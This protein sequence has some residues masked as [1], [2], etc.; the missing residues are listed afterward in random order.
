MS[1]VSEI[2]AYQQVRRSTY[3]PPF[4]L[5]YWNR[6][7][8]QVLTNYLP[9]DAE[10]SKKTLCIRLLVLLH[11]IRLGRT[12]EATSELAAKEG[13]NVTPNAVRQV[14]FKLS[15]RA[16]AH[17]KKLGIGSPERQDP[18][19]PRFDLVQ[20]QESLHAGD[21]VKRADQREEDPSK[22]P[23]RA[24]VPS[25][26]AG[27]PGQLSEVDLA[28]EGNEELLETLKSYGELTR[29]CLAGL[30]AVTDE[31][32]VALRYVYVSETG[33]REVFAH[34]PQHFGL[35]ALGLPQNQ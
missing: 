14:A 5:S 32:D 15:N 24:H 21:G 16:E 23:P 7:V 25:T 27:N 35:E 34:A 22:A 26:F 20:F 4:W 19:V 18:D 33:K 8:K 29:D 17:C 13:F 2:G 12:A 1:E 28:I 6:V 9:S 3:V 11:Y 30:G 31:R 10:E